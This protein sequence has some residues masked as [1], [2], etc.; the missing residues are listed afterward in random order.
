MNIRGILIDNIDDL[1]YIVSNSNL[2]P[3]LISDVKNCED[4]FDICEIVELVTFNET[5]FILWTWPCCSILNGKKWVLG[6]DT[7]PVRAHVDCIFNEVVEFEQDEDLDRRLRVLE[8]FGKI[9]SILMLNDCTSC[10]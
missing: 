10:S 5:D 1:K 6:F 3:E 8:Q 7:N 2:S 9:R 4:G